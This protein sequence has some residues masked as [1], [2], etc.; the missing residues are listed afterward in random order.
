[1]RS[2]LSKAVLPVAVIAMVVA[3]PQAAL[4]KPRPSVTWTSPRSATAGSPIS[5]S[6]DSSHLGKDAKL[7]IQRPVGTARV[8]KT[9]IKLPGDSGSAQL[10]AQPI[11]TYPY[12]LVAFEGKR[13]V[14]KQAVTV[15]VFGKVPF[16]TYFEGEGNGGVYAAPTVSFP[17]ID[18]LY[19]PTQPRLT[20]ALLSV[21]KNNC[22]AVHVEFITG[23]DFPGNSDE[24]SST[25]G[26]VT[27][28]QQTRDP[29]SG[30]AAFNAPG[31]VDAELV[32]GQTWS[33]LGSW[34]GGDALPDI[35]Y[36]GYVVCDSTKPL[37]QQ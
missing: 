13:I 9:V 8:Y 36:N 15:G 6:W 34:S 24:F 3:G 35:Y 11:G 7:V 37:S 21:K 2:V 23:T 1:M 28:V 27:V 14:A 32:P 19:G 18:F 10:P 29:V 30:S 5:V 22:S 17:Y 26:T 4:A 25:V 33:V 16:S 31:S 20:E 12:R